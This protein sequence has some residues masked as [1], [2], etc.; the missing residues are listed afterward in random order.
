M[1]RLLE[2][3]EPLA[4]AD[5]VEVQVTVETTATISADD[6]LC[7]AAG[8]YHGLTTQEIAQ[9]EAMAFKRSHGCLTGTP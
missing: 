8:V 7:R 6:I 2:P 1:N 9:I 5:E 3:L 4:L